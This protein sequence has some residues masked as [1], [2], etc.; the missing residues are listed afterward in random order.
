[1]KLKIGVVGPT[2]SGK[3]TICNLLGNEGL[4]DNA[5]SHLPYR[6]T[7]SI[8]IVGFTMPSIELTKYSVD[9]DCQLWEIGGNPRLKQLWPAIQNNL[10]GVILVYDVNN[11][12]H[13]RDSSAFYMHFVTHS[14]SNVS[15]MQCLIVGNVL[16]GQRET[17]VQKIVGIGQRVRHIA[18]NLDDDASYLREEFR[19][20][21]NGVAQIIYDR[22]KANMLSDSSKTA[23]RFRP[24][25]FRCR[26]RAESP[27]PTCRPTRPVS[28][29]NPFTPEVETTPVL[30]V[31]SPRKRSVSSRFVQDKLSLN[32]VI[33]KLKSEMQHEDH[34]MV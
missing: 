21:M 18:V 34:Q 23:S 17:G 5:N 27:T 29:A 22:E 8:R 13:V 9:V 2:G 19:H 14:P 31:S 12:S 1:M 16:R 28:P 6:P 24:Q 25:D 15:P 7:N 11:D 3:S 10:D 20:F 32:T 33:E 26:T 4:S 30:A